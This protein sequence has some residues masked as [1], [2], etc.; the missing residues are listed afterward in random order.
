[1]LLGFFALADFAPWY[2]ALCTHI[3]CVDVILAVRSCPVPYGASN[4]NGERDETSSGRDEG[5][6]AGAN[7]LSH[8]LGLFYL[9]FNR[10][11]NV[12]AS[13]SGSHLNLLSGISIQ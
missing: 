6:Q 8:C 7:P 3:L 2:V 4:A 12:V 13:T 9:D 11:P 1:V 5:A 10:L